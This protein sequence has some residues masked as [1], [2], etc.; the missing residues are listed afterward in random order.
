MFNWIA[1]LA[2]A[3]DF[4]LGF[5]LLCAAL[6]GA[7]WLGIGLARRGY[8]HASYY[9]ITWQ[10][11]RGM[12]PVQLQY[13]LEQLVDGAPRVVRAILRIVAILLVFGLI[14]HLLREYLPFAFLQRLELVL[15]G[16][17]ETVFHQLTGAPTTG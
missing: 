7:L 3:L 4:P 17:A 6:G 14:L 2:L 1:D 16:S 15:S 5:L 11:E 12:A 8:L 9:V 10:R 13:D